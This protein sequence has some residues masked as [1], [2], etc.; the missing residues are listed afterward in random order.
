VQ[1]L[2]QEAT[3]RHRSAKEREV[4]AQELADR[5]AV[6]RKE[7]DRAAAQAAEVDPDN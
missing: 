7:A 3:E 5:A 6:E 4:Q 2:W 1:E